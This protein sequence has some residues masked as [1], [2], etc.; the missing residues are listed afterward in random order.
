MMRSVIAFIFCLTVL[1]VKGQEKLLTLNEYL[2]MVKRYHPL[3][4]QAGLTN[5]KAM[6]VRMQ[7]LGGF[8][9][10]LEVNGE[11]KIFEGKTYYDYVTS[12][13]KLPLWYGLDLKGVF[14]TYQ[15]DYVNPENK[16]PKSGLGYFGISVPVGRGLLMD[17]RRAALKQAA[18]YQ[19]IAVAEQQQILNDLF[20][21]A[22]QSYAEWLNVWLNTQIYKKAVILAEIRL[23]STTLLYKNG[24][25]AAI[26][27][28]EAL[29]LLQ[30][31]QQKLNDYETVLQNK[32]K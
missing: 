1:Q 21:N 20:I 19:N 26:D 27:T 5:K 6:Y 11:K 16:T 12:E 31:R 17:E 22:T 13:I 32:K 23:R 3:A 29:T 25:K 14:T 24:D 7:A 4:L 15:G 30:S 18:I 9:P 28:L 2:A 10:K 8:D